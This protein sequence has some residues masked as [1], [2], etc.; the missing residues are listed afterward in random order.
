MNSKIKTVRLQIVLPEYLKN[1]LLKAS[2][3]LGV[4]MSEYIKDALKEKLK[5]K[6]D[7]E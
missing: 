4:S 2:E 5:Q 6:K 3:N 1:E 7:A